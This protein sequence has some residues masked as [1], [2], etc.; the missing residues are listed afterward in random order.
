MI[1]IVYHKQQ[2]LRETRSLMGFV[3]MLGKLSQFCFYLYDFSLTAKSVSRKT[4]A[5]HQKSTKT[6]RVFSH[7]TFTVYEWL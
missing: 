1:S 4:F 6:A 7:L 2:Q 5:I 3:I